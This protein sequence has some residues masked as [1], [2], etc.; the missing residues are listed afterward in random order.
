MIVSSASRPML[1]YGVIAATV[2][3]MLFSWKGASSAGQNES[4]DDGTLVQLRSTNVP[5]LADGVVATLTSNERL[6]NESAL[7]EAHA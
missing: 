2:T 7:T 5:D 1:T 6:T 4:D 3:L